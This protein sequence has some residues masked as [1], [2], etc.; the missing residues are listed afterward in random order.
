MKT[1]KAQLAEKENFCATTSRN[2]GSFELKGNWYYLSATFFYVGSKSV[3]PYPYKFRD[4]VKFNVCPMDR[5]NKSYICNPFDRKVEESII[6]E[7]YD[8][9]DTLLTS[10]LRNFLVP[11]W[12]IVLKGKA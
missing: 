7:L 9:N 2:L 10:S 4:T 6:E 3:R 8:Y 11:I 12:N 5:S 1:T